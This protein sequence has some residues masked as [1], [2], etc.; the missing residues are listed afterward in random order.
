MTHYAIDVM[1]LSWNANNGSHHDLA[2]TMEQPECN[3]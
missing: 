1:Q 2:L 3:L